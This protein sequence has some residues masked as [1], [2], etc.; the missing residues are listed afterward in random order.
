M[1]PLLIFD[2][3]G[4]FV[5]KD[6]KY[7]SPKTPDFMI[8]TSSY[9]IHPG[10]TEFIKWVHDN[11]DVAVWSS[12]MPHNTIRIVTKIWGK[13]MKKN[14]KFIFTQNECTYDGMMGEKP[15]FLKEINYLWTMFPWCD[16]KNTLLIDDSEYKVVNNPKHTSIHPVAYDHSIHT[17]INV[18]IRPYLEKILKSELCVREF[19]S[20][21]SLSET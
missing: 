17:N 12:T 10:T 5:S 4:I 20:Q 9:Y 19:V 15:I 21:N 16:P 8:G 11:F 3:N 13:K 6:K 14:L 7:S 1:R 2:L 18:T